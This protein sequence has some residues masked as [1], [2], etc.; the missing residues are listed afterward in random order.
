ML[1]YFIHFSETLDIDLFILGYYMYVEDQTFLSELKKKDQHYK[2]FYVS[3]LQCPLMC[4]AVNFFCLGTFFER[5]QWKNWNVYVKLIEIIT[6]CVLKTHSPQTRILFTTL[7]IYHVT[8]PR[9][10][11]LRQFLTHF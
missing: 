5:R 3:I 11:G 6:A 1:H 8:K 10:I 9:G 4:S 7:I 2:F